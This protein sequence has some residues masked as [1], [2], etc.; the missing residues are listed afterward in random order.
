M[1]IKFGEINSGDEEVV[2]LRCSFVGR[3][4]WE[5]HLLVWFDCLQLELKWDVTLCTSESPKNRQN[6]IF[7]HTATFESWQLNNFDSTFFVVVVN[8]LISAHQENTFC[9]CNS[10]LHVCVLDYVWVVTWWVSVYKSTWC[11]LVLFR[12][13]NT[14]GLA[15]ICSLLTVLRWD[16]IPAPTGGDAE[17]LLG[18]QCCRVS[19]FIKIWLIRGGGCDDSQIQFKTVCLRKKLERDHK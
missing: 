15:F 14:D 1:E 12:N 18:C 11:D 3:K 17:A 13:V 2:W 5:Q 16:L 10:V 8:F 7:I 9:H 4:S 6:V 19:T